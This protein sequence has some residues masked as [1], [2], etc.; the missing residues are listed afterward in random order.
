MEH[1]KIIQKI[2][3]EFAK[4]EDKNFHSENA[5]LLAINFG[6]DEDVNE[7]KRILS[8][9]ERI[10]HM[11]HSLLVERDKIYKKCYPKLTMWMKIYNIKKR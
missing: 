7:A 10:G 8:E 9:H 3:R 5:V 1:K 6:N 4:N 2:A 11:P